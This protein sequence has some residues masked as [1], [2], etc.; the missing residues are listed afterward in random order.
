MTDAPRGRGV[1]ELL[2]LD[3]VLEEKGIREDVTLSALK[4]VVAIKL[5]R[6]MQD[7]R[8][9]KTE[10][11]RKMGTS[12]A[13]LDRVLDPEAHNVTLETLARAAQVVGRRLELTLA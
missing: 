9:S 11:A 12:R 1:E 4:R 6:A 7:Q 3:D 13:Q 5:E 2:S 10:M 8:L